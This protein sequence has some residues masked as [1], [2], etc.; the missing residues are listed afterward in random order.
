MKNAKLIIAFVFCFELIS[1]SQLPK[2]SLG[3]RLGYGNYNASAEISSRHRIAEQIRI[4]ASLGGRFSS[5]Q[6][7]FITNI[8]LQYVMPFTELTSYYLGIGYQFSFAQTSSTFQITTD[9]ALGL[10]ALFGMDYQLKKWT[11][12]IDFRP[13]IDIS[14]PFWLAYAFGLGARYH[15]N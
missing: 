11:I 4:E 13:N 12:S 1:F 5:T 15:I 8:H 7:D 14:K 10:S 6:S 9:Y 3:L 2:N